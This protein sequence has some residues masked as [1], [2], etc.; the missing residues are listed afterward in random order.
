VLGAGNR[1][2]ITIDGGKS[3]ELQVPGP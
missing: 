3:A 1:T 2:V